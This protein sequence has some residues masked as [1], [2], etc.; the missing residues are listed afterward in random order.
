MAAR[1][2][3]PEPLI[4]S[5]DIGT[6]SAR[7]T[8]FDAAGE[9]VPGLS[10]SEGHQP[11][12]TPDGGAELD[13]DALVDRVLGLLEGVCARL[14]TEAQVAGVACCTFWHSMLGVDRS[15]SAVT[16]IYTWADTR[17]TAAED[18]LRG[19]LDETAIHARTGCRF[20]TSYFP[21]R[22]LWLSQTAPDLFRRVA[23]WLSPGEYLYLRLVGQPL[24][25]VSMASG[26]GL[27]DQARLEWDRE[28]LEV[29]PIRPEQ[30][31]PIVP[32]T[33]VAPGVQGEAAARLPK[34]SEVPWIPPIGDGAASNVGSG[35]VSPDR[36]ALMVGTSGAMRALVDGEAVTPPPGLWE[37]RVD[38]ART[39]VGG[40]L[41]NGGN[42][43]AWLAGT[44]RLPDLREVEREVAT[45]APDGHGLTLLPFLAGERSVGWRA[46]ARAAIVGLSWSTRREE[47]LRAG[48][49]T[50]ALRFAQ[51]WRRLEPLVPRGRAIVASGGALL[52]SPVWVQIVTDALNEPVVASGETEASSRGAALLALEALGLRPLS[53]VAFPF[54]ARYEPDAARHAIYQEAMARQERLYDL[55]LV[56]SDLGVRR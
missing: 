53:D 41:S 18:E 13:A 43:V 34:L 20:H 55:L 45:M 46:D 22:L 35:C 37:Y 7:V 40:A 32:L 6:S 56:E 29:L 28:L 38:A 31:S 17:S 39:L 36:V 19:R 33:R 51:I 14:P 10:A 50:V 23:R 16:P 27:L 21:A 25:S 4:L 49:E 11:E 52:A 44:L 30:L 42:L 3:T 54:G 24:C 12:T 26:T 2:K 1:T 15:G 48:L 8:A 47:I 5:I 9:R